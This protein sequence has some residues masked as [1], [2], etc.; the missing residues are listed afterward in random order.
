MCEV[1][2]GECSSRLAE[3]LLLSG[4]DAETVTRSE[5]IIGEGGGGHLREG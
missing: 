4:R 1:H 2:D 3:L 5:A